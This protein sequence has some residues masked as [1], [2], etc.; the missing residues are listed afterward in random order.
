MSASSL[1][2]LPCVPQKIHSYKDFGV[3]AAVFWL[4]N[5]VPTGTRCASSTTLSLQQPL[6]L[7][8]PWAFISLLLISVLQDKLP[9]SE[10]QC[11][12]SPQILSK[13]ADSAL[14]ECSAFRMRRQTE[15]R[16]QPQHPST[17]MRYGKEMET[18]AHP[19]GTV[20]A[21]FQP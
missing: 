8:L 5:P 15:T 3:F 17:T 19:S 16:D 10:T 12:I 13:R 6:S 9:H 14:W 20:P 18:Q 11:P 4:P 2:R 7:V 1:F 21:I